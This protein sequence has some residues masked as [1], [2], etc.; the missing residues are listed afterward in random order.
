LK[1]KKEVLIFEQREKIKTAEEEPFTLCLLPQDFST[2]SSS[3]EF[4]F[5]N[6]L[7]IN[8]IARS[9]SVLT[10]DSSLSFLCGNDCVYI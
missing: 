9:F 6:L 1:T 10:I 5:S 4:Q 3:C 7:K 2:S 8:Q